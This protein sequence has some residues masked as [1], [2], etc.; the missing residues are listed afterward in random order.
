MFRCNEGSKSYKWCTW[1]CCSLGCIWWKVQG[2]RRTKCRK[3]VQSL[4]MLGEY[5][6]IFVLLNDISKILK[7]WHQS[8]IL[9]T[10]LLRHLPGLQEMLVPDPPG[11]N[12]SVKAVQVLC[13]KKKIFI[14]YVLV[15]S[16]EE[17]KVKWKNLRNT[18][19]RKCT[20]CSKSGDGL[21]A[22][23]PKWKF[24]D[25]IMF[26]DNILAERCLACQK[27]LEII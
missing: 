5:T 27:M 10:Y 23:T 9:Q 25:L 8:T 21:A 26:L 17:V 2:S 7:H 4:C 18:Y 11:S 14:M 1:E 22:R 13:W 12:F 19:K 20:E 6:Y 16:F 24:L 3:K 15:N